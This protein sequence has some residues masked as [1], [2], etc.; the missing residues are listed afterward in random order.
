[1]DDLV[2]HT[3]EQEGGQVAAATGAEDDHA[4]LV[5]PGGCDDEPRHMP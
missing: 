4:C 5:V 1:M 3:A 2:G